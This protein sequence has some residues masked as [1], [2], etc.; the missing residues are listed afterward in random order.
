MDNQSPSKRVASFCSLRYGLA[1]VVFFCNIVIVSQNCCLSLTMVTMVNSTDQPGSPNASTKEPLDNVKNP[2]YDWSPKLQGIILSS[3]TYGM[4]IIQIPIGYLS[5]IYPIKKIVGTALFLSSLFSLLL[6]LAAT[7]SGSVVIACRVAQGVSQGAVNLAQFTLWIKWAPPLE[8]GRLTAISLSGM[9]MGPFITLLVTGFI[10]QSLGWPMV[11]YIFGAFGCALSLLWL[12][13]FYEGPKDHP[14]IS[15]TEKEF[16]TS[17]LAEQVI[18]SG[19]SV[20]IKAIIKSQPV[21]AISLGCFGYYWTTHVLHLYAPTFLS[22]Q[23]HINVR[24]NGLLT[25]LPHLI[26]WTFGVLAGHLTDCFLSRKI[27]SLLAI[28]KLFTTLG[29]LLPAL[30]SVVLLYLGSSFLGTAIFLT[31]A[32]ASP[33]F[34]VSG[35]IINPLDIAPRYYGLLKGITVLIGMIGGIISSTLTGIILNQ[36]SESSWFTIF[37]LMAA[38]NM[39]SLIFYLVFAK[40]EI[41]DWAEERQQT[42]L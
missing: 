7:V 10:C 22:S 34:T 3:S 28:R 13:V 4:L 16:I 30:F 8:Q 26:S 21:W 5:G 36:N 23:L 33:G 29:L 14:C 15:L 18:S 17:S 6:P 2:V 31:L 37:V 9:M 35:I 42:H 32:C 1:I 27:L 19:K 12:L 40:A 38:I 41:Q 20:P 11:F 39:I 25:A 24:E